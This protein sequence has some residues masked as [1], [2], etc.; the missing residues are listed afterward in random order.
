MPKEVSKPIDF[1]SA[2]S[3][4]ASTSPMRL[5]FRCQGSVA[6]FADRRALLVVFHLTDRPIQTTRPVM[7]TK[8]GSMSSQF[9]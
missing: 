2:S 9:G 8:A 5:A 7:F 1:V 3:K 4:F 6:P